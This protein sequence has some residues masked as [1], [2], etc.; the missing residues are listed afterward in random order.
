MLVS[1]SILEV[2][3][4]SNDPLVWR[5]LIHQRITSSYAR[6]QIL[7]F[8]GETAVLAMEKILQILNERQLPYQDRFTLRRLLLQLSRAS[9]RIPSSLYLNDVECEERDAIAGGGFADIFRATHQSKPVALKRLRTFRNQPQSAENH[10]NLLREAMVWQQLVHPLIL[11]FLGIDNNTFSPY[12]CLVSPWMHQGNI[13]EYIKTDLSKSNSSSE[14][15]PL[16]H[17]FAEI[18]EGL[19][20]LHD[21]HIIH[22]DLRGANILMG[23]DKRIRIA[24]FGLARFAESS[25]ASLGSQSGGAVRWLAPE[26]VQGSRA[27][28][29]SDSYAFGCVWLEIYTLRHPMSEIPSDH[30]VYAL[31]MR[32]VHPQWPKPTSEPRMK[33]Q[34]DNWSFVRQCW[35]DLPSARPSAESLLKSCRVDDWGMDSISSAS[36][37]DFDMLQ[38]S[39]DVHIDPVD[40]PNP[41]SSPWSSGLKILAL[42]P[43]HPPPFVT[44]PTTTSL[45]PE[46]RSLAR[47]SQPPS[48]HRSSGSSIFSF[49]SV[50]APSVNSMSTAITTTTSSSG[51]FS[52]ISVASSGYMAEPMPSKMLEEIREKDLCNEEGAKE[53]RRGIR[54]HACDVGDCRRRFITIAELRYHHQHADHGTGMD[55]SPLTG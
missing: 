16:G 21:Q 47:T 11:P 42:A 38:T 17:W 18:A 40:P 5:L 55:A 31:K 48:T 12:Y 20:Y 30:Q 34:L 3:R 8:R 35:E 45:T 43:S 54:A 52:F 23:A 39:S 36:E 33:L 2:L 22:G 14:C 10:L 44:P 6:A 13:I 51:R 53:A 32:N 29:M 4:V 46:I 24:D 25:S 26:V 41:S 1:G 50:K 15:I 19:Q 28:F 27:S 7:S 9:S 49:V 37:H